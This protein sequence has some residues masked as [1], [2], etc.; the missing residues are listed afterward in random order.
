[1]DIAKIWVTVV[2]VAGCI[3]CS[4]QELLPD[5]YRETC[6]WVENVVR[7]V[8]KSRVLKQPHVAAQLLRLH[9]HDCFVQGCD[10]SVLLDNQGAIISEKGADPNLNSLRGFD[11][12]DEIKA[13]VEEACPLTVSCADILAIA[14]R[15]SVVLRGGPG[16][17]VLLGRRDSLTAS[18]TGANTFIPTPNL[19]LEALIASFQL[20]GLDIEDLVALSG[21]HTLG[22]ARCVSFRQRIYDTGFEENLYE[23]YSGFR[24]SLASICPISGNDNQKTPLD[25][26]T[27]AFFDNYYYQNIIESKGLLHTD[28]VLVNEDETGEIE[29]RVWA[30]ARNTDLFFESFANSMV[31]MGNIKVLV[32]DEGQIRE[33]CRFVNV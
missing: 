27:P 3:G 25:Y 4:T 17:Q 30:Y 15:D 1:M 8:V 23:R 14:A 24:K 12:I 18:F 29:E 2:L 31:K 6:P 20:Q 32:G 13:A 21:A 9:F 22:V 10:G 7:F 33:N 5:F 11:V 28:N 19:S 16:W 26:R